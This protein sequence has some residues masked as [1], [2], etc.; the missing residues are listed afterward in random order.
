MRDPPRACPPGS[1][2]PPAGPPVPWGSPASRGCLTGVSGLVAFVPPGTERRG[3]P[4]TRSPGLP[5]QRR[6][7]SVRAS[8]A[9]VTVSQRTGSWG[10]GWALRRDADGPFAETAA[11]T[12]H[13]AP[14]RAGNRRP[15]PFSPPAGPAVAGPPD[16]GTPP[17]GWGGACRAPSASGR[18]ASPVSG[19]GVAL[20]TR[21]RGP[22]TSLLA[23]P[24]PLGKARKVRWGDH[25]RDRVT[26]F[27]LISKPWDPGT[28]GP[29]GQL[30]RC[31][32]SPGRPRRHAG[33]GRLA[34]RGPRGCPSSPADR[35]PLVSTHEAATRGPLPA[36]LAHPGSRPGPGPDLNLTHLEASDAGVPGRALRAE[37][38][39][40]VRRAV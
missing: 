18:G 29:W 32:H 28:L 19:A 4:G 40:R 26:G 11:E 16:P 7:G 25:H 20:R 35:G 33:P 1:E 21:P 8:G 39:L 15:A 23:V 3:A 2:G 38:P 13:G 12:A 5:P 37:S 14:T 9:P 34:G 27:R 24:R 6:G 31:G 10:H 17:G 30:C 22:P 36:Q